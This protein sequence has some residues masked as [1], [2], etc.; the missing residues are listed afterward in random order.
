MKK[1]EMNG[2]YYPET[3]CL[4]ETELKYMLLLYDR[5]FFLPID[6]ELNPG[7]TSLSKRFSLLD[8]GL[9]GTF[10]SRKD[11]HY[12]E[13]YASEPDVWDDKMKHLMALYEELEADGVVI[14]L[15]DEEF[16][17]ANKWHPLKDAVDADMKDDEFVSL[18]HRYENEKIFLPMIDNA[19]MK[20]GGMAIRPAF[21]KGDLSM[22][23]LCS[24]RMNAALF[25]A[26]R[27]DLIPVCGNPMYVDLLRIKLKRAASIPPQYRTPPNKAH[28]FS[29]LSWEIVT[30]VV[31][32]NIIVEKSMKD[33][34]RYKEACVN[35]KEEFRSRLWSLEASISSEPWDD[36]FTKELD[37]VVTKDII[38]EVQRIREQKIVIWEKMFGQTLKSL[39]SPK[40][41]SALV[42]IHLVVGLSLWEILLLS[43][44]V[45]ASSVLKNLVDA[46]QQER[47]LRRNALFFL[48][49]LQRR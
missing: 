14:G 1:R 23:S 39:T 35:L 43:T 32:K 3:I 13:M 33:L 49:R 5:I 7:H 24:E 15:E 38:P 45:I 18:C 41:L 8:I 10:K 36:N 47:I 25:V 12:A 48:L 22:P 4:D 19:V 29:L 16:A 11:A 6:N 30:E 20:G 2:L 44:P 31:P 9:T 28:S 27:D 46:W 34:I 37:R 42:G 26:G 21:Y 40:M 17:T